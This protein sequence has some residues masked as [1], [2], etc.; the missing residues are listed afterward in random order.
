MNMRK[1]LI[2]EA[3][4]ASIA[5]LAIMGYAL[6]N[7]E[8]EGTAVNA[9]GLR[10]IGTNEY[11]CQG[12]CTAEYQIDHMYRLF[13]NKPANYSV[14]GIRFKVKYCYDS[15]GYRW[16]QDINDPTD[17]A[18]KAKIRANLGLVIAVSGRENG[19]TRLKWGD[20]VSFFGSVHKAWDPWSD[21]KIIYV[22]NPTYYRVNLSE[23]LS[24]L[25]PPVYVD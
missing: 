5:T 2:V 7:T 25:E 3:A 22:D 13:E 11:G 14:D 10:T 12:Q 16:F 9:F 4:V 8:T 15:M 1:F 20:E 21:A 6:N 19:Y 23:D 18:G 24:L 17:L